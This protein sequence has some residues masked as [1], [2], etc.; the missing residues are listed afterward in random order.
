QKIVIRVWSNISP[1]I[2]ADNFKRIDILEENVIEFDVLD[3]GTCIFLAY[4]TD[5]S[6]QKTLNPTTLNPAIIPEIPIQTDLDKI[7]FIEEKDVIQPSEQH[8]LRTITEKRK[9]RTSLTSPFVEL[10]PR[11]AKT[12][13]IPLNPPQGVWVRMLKAKKVGVGPISGFDWK[14]VLSTDIPMDIS[15]IKILD[16]EGFENG[17]VAVATNF[18]SYK[19]PIIIHDSDH[20]G[21]VDFLHSSGFFDQVRINA[22]TIRH[23]NTWKQP[24]SDKTYVAAIFDDY[25][26][27]GFLKGGKWNPTYFNKMISTTITNFRVEQAKDN[28]Y[29]I[30]TDYTK[31]EASVLLYDEDQLTARRWLK[32]DTLNSVKKA[33]ITTGIHID[34]NGVRRET[35]FVGAVNYQFDFF[36]LYA[37]QNKQLVLAGPIISQWN[38]RFSITVNNDN[39]VLYV[40]S[41]PNHKLIYAGLNSLQQW[42]LIQR[43]NPPPVFINP[44]SDL[45]TI[46]LNGELPI[47]FFKQDD[48]SIYV[49]EGTE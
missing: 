7:V 47:S 2:L 39:H 32:I 25:L 46:F 8:I 9:V 10:A 23:F 16:L 26:A 5:R 3:N 11:T 34:L 48:G 41:D 21:T 28:V 44:N 12:V 45:K 38:E 43:N 42:D 29:A 49:L 37:L 17:A 35:V 40:R 14:L 1:N 20:D 19:K 36:Q 6:V 33:K 24:N 4:T 15:S 22:Q 30:W 31:K 27:T 18:G 13:T